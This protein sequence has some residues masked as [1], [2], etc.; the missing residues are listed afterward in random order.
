[1]DVKIKVALVVGVF[2][3]LVAVVQFC[4]LPPPPPCEVLPPTSLEMGETKTF[5]SGLLKLQ[6]RRIEGQPHRFSLHVEGG[7]ESL[8]LDP[9]RPMMGKGGRRFFAYEG[10]D[11]V[12]HVMDLESG[13]DGAAKSVKL[14]IHRV[15]CKRR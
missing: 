11:Y 13:T 8:P 5:D 12:L 14:E 2:S 3:V 7:L 1:M 9:P 6:V 4:D 10:N 15:D